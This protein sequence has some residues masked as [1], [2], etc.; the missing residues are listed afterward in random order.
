MGIT[1]PELAPYRWILGHFDVIHA[2]AIV[3]QD[4]IQHPGSLE[5]TGL[6]SLAET[7]FFTFSSDSHPDWAKLEALGSK[8]WAANGW[9]C[10][11]QQDPDSL[12]VD[13]SLSDWDPLFASFIW[14]NML[15]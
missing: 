12:G 8:A 3:L 14:E 7:C 6:R 5:S 1:D 11:F 15:L 9:T 2:C 4:L 10:P 13:A